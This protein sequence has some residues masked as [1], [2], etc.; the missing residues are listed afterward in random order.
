[1]RTR[2]D[3]SMGSA[4][5]VSSVLQTLL[6]E[7]ALRTNVPKLS[8]FSGEVAKG[9]VSFDQWSYELQTLRKSYS[10]LALRE[11]I[12]HSLRGAA[13]DVVHN[14]GPDVPLD[15]IIKKFTIIYGNVKSFDL[16]MRDFYRADQGEDESIPS[17]ATRI[18]GL[19]SQI[20]DK[21][22]DQLPLQEE[23]RL[24]KD[25]LF[26][27]SRKGIRDSLKY[28][29]ADASIDY[30][31]FLEECRKSEEEG[32]AGQA[33]APVK[34]KVKAAAAT[35]TPN[36]DDGLSKQLKYQQ[37]QIDALVGQVKDLVAVVKAT[38]T[39]SRGKNGTS[40]TYN[41][42]GNPNKGNTSQQRGQGQRGKDTVKSYQCWQ[43][44]EV[45]HLRRECPALKEKG[46]SPRGN[47]GAAH[48]E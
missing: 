32:K 28:C 25:R 21:F 33:R 34:A 48:R 45:G 1:M 23:Q 26:H 12:Q 47:V 30:M 15:L 3:A 41:G 4:H 2:H 10:D 20:R 38:H 36:K 5:D 39:S 11:G 14:M 29:F 19:L 37:H 16:M 17:Y 31:Q 8:A 24:L 7:G 42:K 40:Y 18:E 22:P 9:E 35:L 44:G 13:A 27:G 46:L 43:C 6:K